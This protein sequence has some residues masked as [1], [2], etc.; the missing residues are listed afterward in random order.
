M[1]AP[2]FLSGLGATG[3]DG[4]LKIIES[5]MDTSYQT[6][7]IVSGTI[8]NVGG[9]TIDYGMVTANLYDKYNNLVNSGFEPFG[10]LK[11]GE[12][13]YFS[14]MVIDLDASDI[15]SYDLETTVY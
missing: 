13:H 6:S 11:P 9:K 1:V 3:V 14:I 15:T 5:H 7:R 4:E 10:H 2:D 12:T 8:Q